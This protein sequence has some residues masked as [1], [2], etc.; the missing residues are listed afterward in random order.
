MSERE[1]AKNIIDTCKGNA[2]ALPSFYGKGPAGPIFFAGRFQERVAQ[3]GGVV[4]PP[5]RGNPRSPNE[6]APIYMP[7]PGADTCFKNIVGLTF[8]S[9]CG[10][11]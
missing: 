8:S 7:V 2:S 5:M 1:H 11:L 4:F 3:G 6:P 10:I 9:K